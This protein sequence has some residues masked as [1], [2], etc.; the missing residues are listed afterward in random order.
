MTGSSPDHCACFVKDKD[1]LKH[2]KRQHIYCT[3]Y[4]RYGKTIKWLTV[5]QGDGWFDMKGRERN[6]GS[7]D[8]HSIIFFTLEAYFIGNCCFIYT[9]RQDFNKGHG[10]IYYRMTQT[11]CM[12]LY[13][14]FTFFPSPSDIWMS[15]ILTKPS[16][17]IPLFV[18]GTHLSTLKNKAKTF[19]WSGRRS[20]HCICPVFYTQ[21]FINNKS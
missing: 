11:I 12:E 6:I 14:F 15:K 19:P 4:H 16:F 20:W 18:S 17:F 3:N 1:S 10:D 13:F 9:R 8:W 5:Q 2:P 21:T 7:L